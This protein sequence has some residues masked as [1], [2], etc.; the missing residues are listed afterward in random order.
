M[1]CIGLTTS[2]TITTNEF[3]NIDTT[4]RLPH[5]YPCPNCGSE[6]SISLAQNGNNRS[7]KQSGKV[8]HSNLNQQILFHICNK[9]NFRWIREWTAFDKNLWMKPIKKARKNAL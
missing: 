9:C 6:S 5:S 4:R 8:L 1:G 3:R 2:R 7:K